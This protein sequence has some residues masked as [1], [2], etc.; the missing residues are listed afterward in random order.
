MLARVPEHA[1]D[2]MAG[3][4]IAAGHDVSGGAG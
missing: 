4:R 3:Q 1:G 2:P